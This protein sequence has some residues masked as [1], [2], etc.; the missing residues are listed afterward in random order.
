MTIEKLIFRVL[1][2]NDNLMRTVAKNLC[3]PVDDA[4]V[5]G[6]NLDLKFV[7]LK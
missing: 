2:R 3:E 7:Y 6:K 1:K 5:I 4:L